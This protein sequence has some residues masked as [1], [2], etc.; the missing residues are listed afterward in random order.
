MESPHR[1]ESSKGTLLDGRERQTAN[2]EH[3]ASTGCIN[4]L[5]SLSDKYLGSVHP[6]VFTTKT[7]VNIHTYALRPSRL[8]WFGL[9]LAAMSCIELIVVENAKRAATPVCRYRF[10]SQIAMA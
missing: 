3:C 10:E 4:L 1:K 7:F 5:V 2:P 9:N 8:F 6:H